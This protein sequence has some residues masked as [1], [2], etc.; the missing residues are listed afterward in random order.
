MPARDDQP[1]TRPLIEKLGVRVDARVCVLG[2]SDSAFEKALRARTA[3]ISTRLRKGCE[4]IVYG[5]D[6]KKQLECL[7]RLREHMVQ[8]GAIWVVSLKGKAATIR[9]VDVIGAAKA[10]RLVDNKVVSFSPSHT[11]LRLVIPLALRK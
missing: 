2:V 5:A 9:D 10:A 1:S 8:N 7:P 6:S 11:A 3:D 4:V